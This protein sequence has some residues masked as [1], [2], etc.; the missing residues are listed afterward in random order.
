MIKAC[1]L[2]VGETAIYI[3]DDSV[4]VSTVVAKPIDDGQTRPKFKMGRVDLANGDYLIGGDYVY[5]S[6]E[7][8]NVALIEKVKK[9]IKVYEDQKL[10]AEG[11]LLVLNNKLKRLIEDNEAI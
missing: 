11:M 10:I 4:K 7:D 5:E 9:Q 8:A 6:P 3:S 1:N 2:K